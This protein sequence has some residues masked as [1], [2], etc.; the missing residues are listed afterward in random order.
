MSEIEE[1]HIRKEKETGASEL[2]NLR[3]IKSYV[4]RG[5]RMTA[6]Q[7]KAYN[8]LWPLYGL[9]PERDRPL[10]IDALFTQSGPLVLEIGFGMGQSLATMAAQS[11]EERFIGVEVH[12]PGIGALLMELEQRSLSNVRMYCCDANE[13]LDH[14]LPAASLDRLQ[15]FFPDP[16]HKKKHHKRRLLQAEFL[17]RA[18]RVLKPGGIFHMATDWEPY[19]EYA[20][21]VLSAAPGYTN[22]AGPG[23]YAPKPAYRPVT[24]FERRGERL[25]HGVWDL[26]FA[27]SD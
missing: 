8:R 13:V 27:R 10:Q 16:W 6:G 18:R 21:A 12:K 25:G 17:Q 15:L 14:C 5:G 7:E 19:A 11:P 4:I 26:L 20:L 22:Q 9:L 3:S 24:K 23:N 2:L 1:S